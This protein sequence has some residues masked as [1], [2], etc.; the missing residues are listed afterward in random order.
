MI[1]SILV[2]QMKQKRKRVGGG[3]GKCILKIKNMKCYFVKLNGR[4]V[5][6]K[7]KNANPIHWS[8]FAL[9]VLE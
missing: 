1:N 6:T 4:L 2:G 5:R 3:A 8:T 7:V 9:A